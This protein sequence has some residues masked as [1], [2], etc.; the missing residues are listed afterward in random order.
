LSIRGSTTLAET[1]TS[2]VLTLARK[3]LFLQLALGGFQTNGLLAGPAAFLL[4]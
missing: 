1:D 3:N 2:V 4:D